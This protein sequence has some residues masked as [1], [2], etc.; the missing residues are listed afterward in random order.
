MPWIDKKVTVQKKQ[1]EKWVTVCKGKFTY[2][3]DLENMYLVVEEDTETGMKKAGRYAGG[4]VAAVKEKPFETL[5]VAATTVAVWGGKQL[6]KT[7]FPKYARIV[8]RMRMP[9]SKVAEEVERAFS[10]EIRRRDREA[11]GK[12]D[13]YQIWECA[14]ICRLSKENNFFYIF[15]K[16]GETYRLNCH[17]GQRAEDMFNQVLELVRK[18]D[19]DRWPVKSVPSI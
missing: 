5:E 4:A 8:S 9:K 10:D 6:Y 17:T 3:E 19:P 14:D 18:K 16:N 1:D 13:V 15:E 7:F 12:R 11:F 2:Y